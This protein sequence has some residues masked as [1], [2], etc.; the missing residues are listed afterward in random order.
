ML[1]QE[2][3]STRSSYILKFKMSG[4]SESV[5]L[6]TILK[7]WKKPVTLAKSTEPSVKR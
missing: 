2:K 4:A 6:V 5:V 1:F 3:I 7:T